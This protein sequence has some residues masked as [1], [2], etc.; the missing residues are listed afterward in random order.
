MKR[1]Q[2][3]F[4]SSVLLL[5]GIVACGHFFRSESLTNPFTDSGTLEISRDVAIGGVSRLDTTLPRKDD[6]ND[7]TVLRPSNNNDT[8]DQTA[9]RQADIK[10]STPIEYEY[11]ALRTSNDP[12]QQP[13]WVADGTKLRQAWDTTT[14]NGTVIA[15]I[16]SGFALS[17]ED[18]SGQWFTNIGESG[19]TSIGDRCW[20]G[21][22]QDKRSNNCDDDS[23]GYKD[24]FRGWD[25]VG[26]NNSPQAGETNPSG[27]GAAHGTQVA[28]LVGAKGNNGVGTATVSWN[29][30]IM[31]L[32][33]LSDDGTGYTSGIAAAVYY[34]VDNGAKV[35]NMSLGGNTDDPTLA[36][37]IKYAYDRNVVVVAAAGNCGTGT[38]QGCD[39]SK[40]GAMGYP[41]L[42]PHVIAVGATTSSNIRASFSSYG[43]GLDVSAPGSGNLVSTTWRSTNQTT[44]YATSLYGTSFASPIVASYVGLLRSV[45]PSSSVD[46]IVAL[47]DGSTS[48]PSGMAGA[49]F[50]ET[51]GH[52]IIDVDAGIRIAGSLAQSQ[53][54]PVLLQAG[55][56]KSEHTFSAGMILSSGCKI[57]QGTYCTV[58]AQN[59]KGYDRFLPYS[60][61]NSANVY[62][63]QWPAE[64]LSDGAWSLRARSGDVFTN[65][66]YLL[67]HK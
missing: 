44:S 27:N 3:F 47:I 52:G 50:T 10:A 15:V 43:A 54:S 32:Q 63:W 18:L 26:V 58:W 36:M 66:P 5:A 22:A 61:L 4:A 28:G 16:D 45:R 53:G 12:L 67:V 46:D 30:T 42:N 17:H 13:S 55:S 37:A 38:E 59:E 57:T 65:S 23:N 2:I 8:V 33:A 49:P 60:I 34:A 9:P 64:W 48:K 41:A 24:D 62:G 56:T 51:Y 14:G 19:Q 6:T 25:F 31:P 35:I 7:T 39:S 21:A 20:T 40:P 1:P 29:N 11:R